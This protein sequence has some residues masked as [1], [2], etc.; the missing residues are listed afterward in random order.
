MNIV[1]ILNVDAYKNTLTY[2]K[3]IFNDFPGLKMISIQV[4]GRRCF[5]CHWI[6][7]EW[8]AL[9]LFLKKY[10]ISVE[11]LHPIWLIISADFHVF[12]K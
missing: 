7:V 5:E 6:T 10:I 2:S 8:Y 11:Y 1:L 12:A 9:T 3:Q 4:A